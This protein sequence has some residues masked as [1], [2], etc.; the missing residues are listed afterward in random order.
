MKSLS[1]RTFLGASAGSL[2]ALRRAE[3]VEVGVDR[4]NILLICSDQQ[5]GRALGVADPFFDTPAL[6]RL[7]TSG[8]WFREAFCTTPQCSPSRST[9]YTGLYPHRTGVLGNLDVRR[10]DGGRIE[11]MAPGPSTLGRLLKEAGYHTGYFGKWHLGNRDHYAADFDASDLDGDAHGGVT[12][13]ALAFLKSRAK[14]PGSP[15][16]LF[17]NYVNPHD[18]YEAAKKITA[19]TPRPEGPPV[20]RPASWA[21]T[22]EGKPAPQ[23]QFLTEDQGKPFCDWP[24][25]ALERYRLAYREKCRLVDRE[26]GRL[27][28]ALDALHMS[29]NTVV[30]YVSDHGDMDTHHR[31][32]YKGPFMYDQLVRVPLI[33]RVP[34][35]FGGGAGVRN[36][37][38]VSLADVTPT[39]CAL[40]RRDAPEGDGM[41]LVPLLS[42]G[43]LSAPREGVAV[44]YYGKQQWVNPIRTWRTRD[45]KYNRY[46]EH[47]E[48]LYDLRNDPGEM[49]NLAGNPACAGKQAEMRAALDGWMRRYGDAL[50]DTYWPT[51]RQGGRLQQGH[52]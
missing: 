6:D 33:I 41:S 31:L 4:P 21:D 42:G 27:L 2:L 47:G 35:G 29:E 49:R 30:V 34:E 43:A 25:A 18:I 51:D 28:D 19:D 36:D 24:D 37:D 9:L 38:L 48:E 12:E 8:V 17:V 39:L 11:A 7:A 5:H 44:Q 20:P 26:V 22:L 40:A 52:G 32:V 46:L 50:F 13:K 15:F 14:D 16:A 45:W 3:A 1:R 10:H 23:R